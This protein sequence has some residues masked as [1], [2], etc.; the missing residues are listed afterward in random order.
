MG[1]PARVPRRKGPL[2]AENG[3][4]GAGTLIA[5]QAHRAA[6]PAHHPTE[7]QFSE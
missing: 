7:R 3:R 6:E 2:T 1:A 5:Q 4:N